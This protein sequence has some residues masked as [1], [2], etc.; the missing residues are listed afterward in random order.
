MLHHELLPRVRKHE[1]LDALLRLIKD[2]LIERGD[3]LC[4]LRAPHRR[5]HA[6]VDLEHELFRGA[7]VVLAAVAQRRLRVVGVRAL[8]DAAQAPRQRQV[9]RLRPRRGREGV[10]DR[11][12][13]EGVGGAVVAVGA[14]VGGRG[15]ED[16]VEVALDLAFD[17]DGEGGAFLVHGRDVDL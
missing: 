3:Q 1:I 11:A 14:A 6:R 13:G 15:F 8:Q 12:V 5:P 7:H 16:R 9:D 17:V 2:M 10:V 4:R